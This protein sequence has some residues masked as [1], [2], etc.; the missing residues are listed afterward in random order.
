MRDMKTRYENSL[1]KEEEETDK[2][3]NLL[4]ESDKKKELRDK[5]I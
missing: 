5:E 4:E 2:L 3:M 1:V